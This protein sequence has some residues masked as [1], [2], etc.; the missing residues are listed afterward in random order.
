MAWNIF[1]EDIVNV[2][3]K[4]GFDFIEGYGIRKMGTGPISKPDAFFSDLERSKDLPKPLVYIADTVEELA[5]QIHVPVEN[6]KETV[7]T[8]NRFCETGRDLDYG[9]RAKYLRPLT[10][11]L[12]AVHSRMILGVGFPEGIS[13]SNKLEALTPEKLPIPGLYAA[14]MDCCRAIWSDA[15]VNI[16][17][18]NA[19][20]WALNSGRMAGENASAYVKT[21]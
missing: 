17:P 18:G 21:L 13:V 5:E 12:Y 16:L 10:G 9:K 14:G 2:Y 11:K 20:G 8:Y 15:Y 4:T 19:M 3:Q 1:S 7:E 6:L